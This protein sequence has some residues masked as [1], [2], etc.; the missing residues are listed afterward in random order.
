MNAL[1]IAHPSQTDLSAP[2]KA[3]LLTGSAGFLF[4]NFTAQVLSAHFGAHPDLGLSAAG[5]SWATAVY[6]L[7]SFVGVSTAQS[8]EHRFGMRMYFVAVA[9]LLSAFGSLQV[10]MPSQPLL[11]A[12]RAFEG[13]ASGSFGPR[14]LLAAFLFCRHG[15]LPTAVALAAFFLLVAAVIGFVMF[16]A[17]ESV[18]GQRGLFLVQFVMGTLLA[19]AGLRWLPRSNNTRL[20]LE[21]Q[22]PHAQNSPASRFQHLGRLVREPLVVFPRGGSAQPEAADGSRHVSRPGCATDSPSFRTVRGRNARQPR[23]AAGRDAA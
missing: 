13:F 9:L 23:H 3:V 5:G 20:P 22:A 1:V 17:S 6:T 4:A 2:A 10:L 7:A 21:D 16:G 18:L 11:L 15:R 12:M 8:I 14:A 19:L